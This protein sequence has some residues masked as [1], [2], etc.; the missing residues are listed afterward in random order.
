MVMY[1]DG[2]TEARHA[3]GEFFGEERFKEFIQNHEELPAGRF[4]DA[5]IAHIAAWSGKKPG[6]VLDDDLTLVVVDVAG[7]DTA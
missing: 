5:L 4:T 3:S 2:I 7:R 1:T 6:G